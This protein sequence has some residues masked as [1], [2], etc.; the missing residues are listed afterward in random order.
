MEPAPAG[1][2]PGRLYVPT[3]IRPD[4]LSWAHSSALAG[5]P[6]TRRTL[7]YLQRAFWWSA[8]ARDVREFVQ[9]CPVCARAKTNN[10]PSPGGL[11]PLPV[12]RRPWSHIALDF[13]TGLPESEG[14]NAIL[15]IVDRFSKAVH[16]VALAGLPSAKTTA[17]LIL[18]HVV[19]LHGFPR[20]I[21]SDRGPQFTARFWKAICRLI[22]STCSLSSGYHP[23]TNGQTERTNQQLERYLRCFVADRQ[24]SWARYLIWAELS[25]NHHTSSATGLSP[26]EV[27]NG[28]Q[29]PMFDYQEPEV[30][31]PSAQQ[32]V[33]RCRKL[34]TQAHSAIKKAN[35]YYAAQHRR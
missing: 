11:H 13:I 28:F 4:V 22:N 7:Q 8:M 21:V 35:R 32:L 33:H 18:E 25:H 5:H 12:P 26:F 20:D 17:E 9:A 19:R 3:S 1:S 23:Q 6:G 10:Q 2:P 31:V 29:P 30:D 16:L 14:K 27:C 15:T 34:W 24:R